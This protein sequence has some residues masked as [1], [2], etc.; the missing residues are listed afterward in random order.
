MQ[1]G[2]YI[3]ISSPNYS[4]YEYQVLR[5]NHHDV[6]FKIPNY[7]SID[8]LKKLLKK[9]S[10]KVRAVET[11]GV[12]DM[13]YVRRNYLNLEKKI[14]LDPLIENIILSKNDEA[15]NLSSNLQMYISKNKL[16]GSM[17]L[18]AEKI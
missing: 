18:V 17:L 1:P 6:T 12:L 9:F 15:K 2:G 11:P 13:Q 10:F 8:T 7:F 4:G 5:E 16:S 14:Q 3:F